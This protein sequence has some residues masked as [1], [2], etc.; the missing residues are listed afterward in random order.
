MS[1]TSSFKKGS[2]VP[3]KFRVC[4]ASGN[5]IGSPGVVTLFDLVKRTNG[6]TEE[7]APEDIFS[8]TPDTAFRWSSTDQQWIFNLSTKGLGAGDYDFF[9]TAEGDP[10]EHELS[11]LL[12]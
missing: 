8:T 4:D 12:I 10:T 1:T 9:W 5:S 2:T 7:T 6:T 3:V 11:F